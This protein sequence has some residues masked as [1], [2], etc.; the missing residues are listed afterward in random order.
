M[1]T[2]FEVGEIVLLPFKVVSI[3]ADL[4]DIKY[5]LDPQVY[6]HNLKLCDGVSEDNIIKI[7]E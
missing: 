5:A 2:K 4:Y 7:N 1:T 3:R 6:G